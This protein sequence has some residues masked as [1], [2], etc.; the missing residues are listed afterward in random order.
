MHVCSTIIASLFASNS[1][2]IQLLVEDIIA[3]EALISTSKRA[4]LASLITSQASSYH[5]LVITVYLFIFDLNF[6]ELQQKVSQP[7]DKQFYLF[8]V[9]KSHILPLTNVAFNKSGSW[10]V[11][12]H[13]CEKS[14]SD[15][16]AG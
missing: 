2:D 3:Q 5:A 13:S 6:S 7:V 10:W 15:T 8:K 14:F 9:I 11:W 4:Q 12:F 1:T 16:C